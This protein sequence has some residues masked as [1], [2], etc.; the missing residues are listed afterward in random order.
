MRWV[1][2][3]LIAWTT[4][5]VIAA[6]VIGRAIGIADRKADEAR[7]AESRPTGSGL[8][9]EEARDDVR[10]DEYPRPWLL[11]FRRRRRR[12]PPARLRMPT[13]RSG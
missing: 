6:F 7:R 10:T 3:V 2:V 12:W 4:V 8:S 5:A 11:R 13:R 1:L 9:T